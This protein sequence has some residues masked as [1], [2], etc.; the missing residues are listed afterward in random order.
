MEYG[1]RSLI[2][3]QLTRQVGEVPTATTAMRSQIEALAVFSQLRVHG[4]FWC[5]NGRI[6]MS[7]SRKLINTWNSFSIFYQVKTSFAWVCK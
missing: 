4:N 1:E 6:K 7:T 2:L 5:S 3:R